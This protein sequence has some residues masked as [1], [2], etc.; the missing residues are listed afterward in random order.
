M[1]EDR[2]KTLGEFLKSERERRGLTIEQTSSA[3]KIGLK[4]L[5]QLEADQYVDLPALPFVRGFI[6]N[7]GKFLGL[8]GEKL[9]QEYAGFLDAHANERPKR[10]AGHSG[11]AFERPE[12]EQSRKILWGVM[13]GMLVF[14]GAVVFLFKPS[15]KR[16]H[17]G[18]VDKMKPGGGVD[19]ESGEEGTT[20]NP[21]PSV[22][23]SAAPSA[24]PTPNG[25]GTPA[26]FVTPV[27]TAA[28][29]AVSAPSPT[30]TS[31]PS[32]EAPFIPPK[33]PLVLAPSP[34]PVATPI[35]TE[36]PSPASTATPTPKTTP[37]PMASASPD[38]DLKNDPLQSGRN[39]SAK[40]VRV[41]LVLRTKADLWVRYQ[42][43]DK[44][45][46]K[47]SLKKDKILVLRGKA[48]VYVQVSNP[49]SI[50][51]QAPGQSEV[52]FSQSPAQF[53]FH[54]NT[55][56][57]FPPQAREKMEEKFKIKSPLPFTDA[58]PANP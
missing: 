10:D 30:P 13:A 19:S 25:S 45:L 8:D 33:V 35:P 53:D 39:Y 43:D 21:E 4:I 42:C 3:T 27:P 12:G 5:R 20:P 37:S 6:R 51:I 55:S 49:D 34:I 31:I 29:A 9:L 56:A 32:P 46:I 52:L 2:K 11:Y 44:Q 14:G 18:H 47:F 48:A 23:A 15:L 36:T 17:H 26:P 41:K 57:A 28:V 58:P 7:Y 22:N 1:S 16:K 50:T 38:D 40:E 54:G 24:S